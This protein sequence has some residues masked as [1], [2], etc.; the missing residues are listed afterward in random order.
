MKDFKLLNYNGK[1]Y[2]IFMK[3][4]TLYINFN[5][6]TK[7]I[8]ENVLKYSLEY[9]N[10]SLWI[11][12]YNTIQL[13]ILL[14]ISIQ[15]DKEIKINKQLV[16][17]TKG[18][19][20]KIDSL[21]M[22]IKNTNQINLVF[23]GWNN[24]KSFIFNSNISICNKFNIIS[25]NTSNSRKRP[26][27]VYS[28]DDKAI[29]LISEKG[30]CEEYVLYNLIEDRVEESFSLPNTSDV[31][32]IKYDEKPIIFYNKRI[33]SKLYIRYRYIDIEKEEENIHEE[34]ILNSLP[35]DIIN[36]QISLYMGIIYL[37]WKSNRCIRSAMSRNLSNWNINYSEECIN[38][39]NTSII[40]VCEDRIER[41]NTY[42]KENI[43][44]NLIVN[45]ENCKIRDQSYK[46]LELMFYENSLSKKLDN[47]NNLLN[48]QQYYNSKNEEYLSKIRELN[49]IIMEKDKIIY[50]LLSR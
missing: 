28:E 20:E 35:Q 1:L 32:M 50:K 12:I 41:M 16:I 3:G 2:K 43:V 13:I 26:F 39:I 7:V 22:I 31:S 6:K 4:K 23:R 21:T 30:Q 15:E 44:Y 10:K 34:K 49:S 40:K 8:S 37:V 11:S 19:S 42:M 27:S 47:M 45:R 24:N 46:L 29:L 25:D 48:I 5:G 38:N 9:F 14:E 33:D 36:P 18:Y 17:D